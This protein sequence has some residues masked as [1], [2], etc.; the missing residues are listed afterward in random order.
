[1]MMPKDL[2][3]KTMIIRTDDAAKRDAENLQEAKK[4][5]G[6]LRGHERNRDE[7]R[8]AGMALSFFMTLNEQNEGRPRGLNPQAGGDTNMQ[9]LLIGDPIA[10]EE[11]RQLNESSRL[12]K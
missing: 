12:S 1:M 3:G 9:M 6:E 10:L 4:K 11:Q 5:M 8:E 7:L 2:M